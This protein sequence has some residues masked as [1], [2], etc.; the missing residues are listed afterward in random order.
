MR[1]LLLTE[2]IL[3]LRG[4]TVDVKNQYEFLPQGMS[5]YPPKTYW[6]FCMMVTVFLLPS[7]LSW[8]VLAF[9]PCEVA[10]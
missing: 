9:Q 6:P 8:K 7:H 1:V 2:I 4:T 5:V 10:L 3:H